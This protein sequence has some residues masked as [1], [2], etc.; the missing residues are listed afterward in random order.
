[1]PRGIEITFYERQQIELY[2]NMKKKKIWIADKLNRDYSV[3][4]REIK[5]NSGEHLPYT[6]ITAQKYSERRKRN[7]NKRK[8]DKWQNVPLKEYVEDR[9]N[10]GWSPD[11]IAGRLKKYHP[12]EVSKS[13]DKTISYESIYDWVYN[14]E[15]RFGGLYKKLRRKQRIRK[16]KF[17]RK[18]RASGVKERIFIHERPSAI[19]G[20]ERIGDWETDS[21]IFSGKSTLCVNYERKSMK[22]L[23]RKCEDKS[24]NSFE[25]LLRDCIESLPGNMWLSITRDTGGENVLHHETGV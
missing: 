14:G 20:R 23:I 15:G 4:K 13:K 10:E 9:L 5:R 11:E 7:T 1:M 12:D 2:L 6:A 21:V 24:A 3:I 22:A 19:D 8:L 16:R 18:Y 17:S 25:E